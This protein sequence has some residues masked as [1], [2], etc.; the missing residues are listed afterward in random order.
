[1]PYVHAE[2]VGRVCEV[3]DTAADLIAQERDYAVT[4]RIVRPDG[5]L[6]WVRSAACLSKDAHG[7]AIRAVGFILDVT[8]S[9]HDERA[10]RDANRFS[11]KNATISSG[12]A[13]KIR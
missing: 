12:K 5:T 8:E 7:V 11:R 9:L 6:R 10:L 13:T 3:R 4:Y 2:D 1:M